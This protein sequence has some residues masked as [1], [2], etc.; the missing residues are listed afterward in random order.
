MS[1]GYGSK[2]KVVAID[3]LGISYETRNVVTG[4]FIQFIRHFYTDLLSTSKSLG[5]DYI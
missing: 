3:G 2:Y 5:V 4:G 1:G